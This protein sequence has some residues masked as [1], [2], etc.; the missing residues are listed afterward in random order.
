MLEMSMTPNSVV[1]TLVKVNQNARHVSL[2][3]YLPYNHC[4][5]AF[6]KLSPQAGR[7]EAGERQT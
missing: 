5:E 2:L 7:H 6:H 1:V 3:T 4:G